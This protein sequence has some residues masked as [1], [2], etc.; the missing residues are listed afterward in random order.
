MINFLIL[1]INLYMLA[2]IIRVIYSWVQPDTRNPLSRA[3][4]S[5]TDPVLR[6]LRGAIPPIADR[7][8]VSPLVVLVFAEIVKRFLVNL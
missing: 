2:L 5:L 7:I 4:Y 3:I 8:D 1:L 6:P